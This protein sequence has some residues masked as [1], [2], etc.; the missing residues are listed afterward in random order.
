MSEKGKC[1]T[2]GVLLVG[3]VIGIALVMAAKSVIHWSGSNEFCG[4]FCHSMDYVYAA[5]QKG[6]HF[7]TKSGVTAGCTDCHLKNES[8]KHYT[9]LDT[10][11]M[12]I[13]KAESGL[14]SLFGEIRG[15]M[16]TPEK[17]RAIQKELSEKYIAWLRE[18]RY[19]T[20]LGCHELGKYK[21]DPKKPMVALLHNAMAKEKKIDCLACHKT[22]GHDYAALKPKE[23]PKATPAAQSEP[24]KK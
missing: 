11:G 15:T 5:Y 4:T 23:E 8:K 19:S 20:C 17:Q 16:S 1:C 18:N 2:A 6:Q 7:Q 3:A 12:L 22:A 13:H 24:E 9:H 14:S 21:A 10:V